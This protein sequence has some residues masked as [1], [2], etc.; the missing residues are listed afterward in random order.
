MGDMNSIQNFIGFSYTNIELHS[1]N[2][3]INCLLAAEEVKINFQT[4]NNEIVC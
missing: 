3:L 4:K 2:S 1:I